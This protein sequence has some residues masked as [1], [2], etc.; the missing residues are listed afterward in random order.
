MN[1]LKVSS[2]EILIN[3]NK[4]NNNN[5]VWKYLAKITVTKL[6]KLTSAIMKQVSAM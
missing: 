2:Q 6:S 5:F 1:D 4:G 3:N